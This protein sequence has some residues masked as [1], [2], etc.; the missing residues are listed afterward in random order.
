MI[1][2]KHREKEEED[3]KYRILETMIIYYINC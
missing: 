1:R 3:S 2:Y